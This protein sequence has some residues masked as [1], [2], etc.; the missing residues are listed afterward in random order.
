MPNLLEISPESIDNID[1]L[2]Q[3]VPSIYY[4]IAE[5]TS[6]LLSVYQ[7]NEEYLGPHKEE[8]LE[9]LRLIQKAIEDQDNT[10]LE[11]TLVLKKYSSMAREYLGRKLL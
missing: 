1:L 5:D 2:T 9:L 6:K 11:L 10:I 4:R 8:V 3:E 7:A